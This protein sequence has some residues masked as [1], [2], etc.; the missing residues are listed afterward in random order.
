MQISFIQGLNFY[1]NGSSS[2]IIKKGSIS[3]DGEVYNLSN[4]YNLQLPIINSSPIVYTVVGNLCVGN[5]ITISL[6]PYNENDIWCIYNCSNSN[7]IQSIFLGFVYVD[8]DSSKETYRTDYFYTKCLNENFDFIHLVTTPNEFLYDII[9][10]LEQWEQFKFLF[11]DQIITYDG[12]FYKV[13]K[14][15]NSSENIDNDVYLGNL[16][17][18]F[19]GEGPTGF[20]GFQGPA[21]PGGGD[22]GF[23]GFQGDVGPQGFQG[24]QGF[25]GDTG[26]QGFQGDQGFQGSVGSNGSMGPIGFQG[27][28]GNTGVQGPQGIEGQIGFQGYQGDNG[29]QGFQG[30]IGP[31]GANTGFQGFQG[32]Q[33]AQGFQGAQGL[34][35]KTG[36]Q[37]FQGVIGVQGNTGTQGFQGAQGFQ[38]NTGVQGPQGNQ[39]TQGEIGIRGATGVQG[40]QGNTGTQGPQGDSI[41]GPQG[42]IGPTGVCVCDCSTILSALQSGDPA[43]ISLIQAALGI[44]VAGPQ[45]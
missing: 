12:K 25:Q 39:G 3:V 17:L 14:N 31:Q 37:G 40:F 24:S 5:S 45:Q 23:Q 9:N 10:K 28:Q 19:G 44:V 29:F 22:Q 6:I 33:G 16:K 20:Q 4:D 2:L 41:Q 18:I 21:G 32:T 34:Q 36:V 27:A 30:N 13:L 43:C 11:K 38:G 8:Y 42:L 15:Y 7:Q 35:G 1:Y 26:F